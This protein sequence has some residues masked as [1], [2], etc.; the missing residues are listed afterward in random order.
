[1]RVGVGGSGGPGRRRPGAATGSGWWRR[2]SWKQR[3]WG[4]TW[5]GEVRSRRRSRGGDGGLDRV[6]GGGWGK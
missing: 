1:V 6:G 4:E 5:M 3:K 2:R